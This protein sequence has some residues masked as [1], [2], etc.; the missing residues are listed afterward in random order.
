MESSPIHKLNYAIAVAEWKGAD[1]AL[2]IL[3]GLEPPTWLSG[4]YLWFAVL[5]DLNKRCENK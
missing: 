3:D 4:S 1:E 2:K 5:A